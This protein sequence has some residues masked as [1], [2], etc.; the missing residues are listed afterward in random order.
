MYLLG[1]AAATQCRNNNRSHPLS[2]WRHGCD[3]LVAA[4]ALAGASR[5]ERLAA[6]LVAADPVERLLLQGGDDIYAKRV[7]ASTT[8]SSR[9]S[10]YSANTFSAG[11]SDRKSTKPRWREVRTFETD[12]WAADRRLRAVSR[13]LASHWRSRHVR[14]SHSTAGRRR[15]HGW[16]RMTVTPSSA[17]NSSP[18]WI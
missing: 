5:D 17:R 12:G 16:P 9:T 13:R 10:R 3:E 15:Y 18:L 4:P 6:D 7:S 8:S 11:S 1:G 14:S 2:L